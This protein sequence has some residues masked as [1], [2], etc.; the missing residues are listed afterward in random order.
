MADGR[1]SAPAVSS[2]RLRGRS[3][4]GWLIDTPTRPH[5][6]Q[7]RR[8]AD[9]RWRH[10][11]GRFVSSLVKCEANLGG[12]CEKSQPS[13]VPPSRISSWPS[14]PIEVIRIVK[15]RPRRTQILRLGRCEEIRDLVP[16]ANDRCPGSERH[17]DCYRSMS[18]RRRARIA[19]ETRTVGSPELAVRDHVVPTGGLGGRPDAGTAVPV[20]TYASRSCLIGHRPETAPDSRGRPVQVQ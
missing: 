20:R 6:S 5:P 14:S 13:S 1:L 9:K 11:A 17:P 15:V 3:S 8:H 12:H 4:Q 16:G 2:D 7:I 19:T 10:A 18:D